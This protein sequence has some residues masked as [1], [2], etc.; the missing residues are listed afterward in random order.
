MNRALL[1]IGVAAVAVTVFYV[2]AL[3]GAWAGALAAAV[4]S[5]ALAATAIV[6]RRRREARRAAAAGR[7]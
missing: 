7:G 4:L 6:D 2:T 3:W 5:L 1:I